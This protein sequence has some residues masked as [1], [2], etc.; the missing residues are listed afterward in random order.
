MAPPARELLNLTDDLLAAIFILLPLA[1]LGRA[2]ASCAAFHRVITSPSFLRRLHALH[3]PTLLGFRTFF[4][5]FRPVNPPHPSAAAARALARAADFRFSFL[6]NPGFWVVRD[7]RDGRFLV[8]YGDGV[9]WMLP[10]LAVCDPLFRRHVLLPPIP[11]DLAAAVEPYITTGFAVS[12]YAPSRYRADVLLAPCGDEEAAAAAV[13]G[14]TQPFRVIW[15][16][17]CA[18]KLV[19]LV[20]SSASNQW[21]DISSHIW[22]DLKPDMPDLMQC[23]RC[24]LPGGYAYGCFYWCLSIV[25]EVFKLLVLDMSTMKFSFI[26]PLSEPF[27]GCSDFAMVELGE[28]RRGMFLVARGRGNGGGLLQLFCANGQ[29]YGE[30]ASRWVLTKEVPLPWTDGHLPRII[31]YADGTLLVQGG[32][33]HVSSSGQFSCMSFDFKTLQSQKVQERLV[34]GNGDRTMPAPYIGYPPSLASPT[35]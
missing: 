13:A 18:S 26:N 22:C 31:G 25:S 27:C 16:A 10:T 23:N 33:E 6:P 12:V 14:Q 11:R 3:P 32:Q 5:S 21:R 15:I 29:S 28:S 4:G 34:G 7:V 19:T 2:C 9:D 1:D 8:E 17:K 20:F 35:I 30:D 24:L